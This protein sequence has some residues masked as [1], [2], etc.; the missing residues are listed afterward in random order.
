MAR[1]IVRVAVLDLALVLM[2]LLGP[3]KLGAEVSPWDPPLPTPAPARELGPGSYVCFN[4]QGYPFPQDSPTCPDGWG[5][6]PPEHP[7]PVD[8]SPGV[9]ALPPPAAG[10]IVAAEASTAE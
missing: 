7:L 2:V 6:R 4:A 3:A 8:G 1:V 10:D 9:G 5:G